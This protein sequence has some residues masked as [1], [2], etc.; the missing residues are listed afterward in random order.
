LS[1]PPLA[2]DA[3]PPATP[4]RVAPDSAALATADRILEAAEACIRRWG[5]RRVSMNDVA[6]TAECSRGSVY[7]YFPDRNALV[8]AVLKRVSDR[9]IA[10]AQPVVAAQPTMA[11]K[12]AE[13]VVFVLGLVDEETTLGLDEH[14]GEPELATLRLAHDPKI[15]ER[16]VDFWIPF[17]DEAR[18]NG[19][20]RADLDL[21]QASEWIMRILLS[22]VTVPSVTVDLDDA[23]QVRA[24]VEAHLVRGFCD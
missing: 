22:L 23:A 24:F 21:R 8:D 4:E 20:L 11:A 12:A 1:T 14:P 19:E 18:A 17:L 9:A 7:R 5:M 16:W 3:Q 15:F 13:A 10:A 6:Q 2:T